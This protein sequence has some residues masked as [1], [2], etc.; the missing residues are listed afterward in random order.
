[1]PQPEDGGLDSLS[2]FTMYRAQ[3]RSFALHNWIMLNHT[4]DAN[5]NNLAGG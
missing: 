3:Y 4:V 1:M 5:G 2:Q